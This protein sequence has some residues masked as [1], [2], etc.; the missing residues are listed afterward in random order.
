MHT[1]AI[2]SDLTDPTTARRAASIGLGGTLVTV[3]GGVFAQIMTGSS[4]VS[5]DRWS[6]PF[7]ARAHV[8]LSGVWVLSHVLVLV[9]LR[10]LRRSGI[11]TTRRPGLVGID[12][13]IAGTALLALGEIASMWIAG[14]DED[15]A[16][17]IAVG[18]LFGLGTLLTAIGMVIYGV[19]VLR[20]RR[21]AVP[22]RWAALAFGLV[23][24]VQLGLAPTDLFFVGIIAYGVTGSLFMLAFRRE[25]AGPSHPAASRVSGT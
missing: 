5:P 24:V 2:R 23:N 16:S 8:L 14:A 6:Y 10:G 13:A 22:G 4:A 17:A 1:T 9:G 18:S 15:A 25:V 11:A 3:A 19:V 20:D 12:L 7:S 21:W